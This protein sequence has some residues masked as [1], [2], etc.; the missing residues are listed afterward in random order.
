MTEFASQLNMINDG[1]LN[2]SRVKTTK[3]HFLRAEAFINAGMESSASKLNAVDSNLRPSIR[4]AQ[5]NETPFNE[6]TG[7]ERQKSKVSNRRH[8]KIHPHID[9]LPPRI[10]KPLHQS[11]KIFQ[12]RSINVQE[13]G[14]NEQVKTMA[15]I[16]VVYRSSYRRHLN[17]GVPGQLT[18]L[19]H[20]PSYVTVSGHHILQAAYSTACMTYL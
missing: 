6:Q 10:V 20:P 14:I 3:S 17:I 8:R 5:T 7:A 12:S 18:P 11:H 13:G 15:A 1:M 19:H 9:S 4:F 2:K 16:A